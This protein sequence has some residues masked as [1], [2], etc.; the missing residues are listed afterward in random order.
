MYSAGIVL[1]FTL[2][3]SVVLACFSANGELIEV[4]G[5]VTKVT[6][7]GPPNYENIESGDLP[8][9][10]FVLISEK[11]ICIEGIEEA[12]KKFQLFWNSPSVSNFEE[13]V[14]IVRGNTMEAMTGHHHTKV[15]IEVQSAYSP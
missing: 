4:R 1:V 10:V 5:S 6:F 11:E 7:P 14:T 9:T 12:Q 3:P 13:G 15:L 8:E 2:L